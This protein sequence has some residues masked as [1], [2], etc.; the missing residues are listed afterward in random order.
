MPSASA[1]SPLSYISTTMSQ[2][3]TSSPLTNSW[4]IVGQF[5]SADSSWRIRGSG[6][7]STAANGAPVASR[8]AMVRAEKPHAGRSGVPFMKRMTS[9][10]LI[11]SAIASRMGFSV[12]SLISLRSRF[13]GQRMDRPADVRPDHRVHAAVLLDPAH[14]GGLGRGH[15]GAGMVPAAGEIGHL[16]AGPWD[17]GLDAV[18]ELLGARHEHRE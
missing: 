8:A 5:D 3:P 11:A 9:W 14:A 13:E 1:S 15:A 16:G 2:P 17:R 10:S 4:G 7:M 12:V 6:R 18:L